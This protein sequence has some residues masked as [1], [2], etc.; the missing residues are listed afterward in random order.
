MIDNKSTFLEL[1]S[2]FNKNQSINFNQEIQNKLDIINDTKLQISYLGDRFYQQ[3]SNNKSTNKA[4]KV[5]VKNLFLRSNK[6]PYRN[7]SRVIFK[8]LVEKTLNNLNSTKESRSKS[9]KK[10]N[11]SNIS[12]K[13]YNKKELSNNSRV[14]ISN[15][16]RNVSINYNENKD[17]KDSNNLKSSF[18]FKNLTNNFKFND[19]NDII[20]TNSNDESSFRNNKL[21]QINNLKKRSSILDQVEIRKKKINKITSNFQSNK[22]LSISN[23][24]DFIIKNNSIIDFD[25]FNFDLELKKHNENE[26]LASNHINSNTNITSNIITNKKKQ[27]LLNKPLY[28]FKILTS[29]YFKDKISVNNVNDNSNNNIT[30][31]K[32]VI[33][34]DQA[35]SSSKNKIDDMLNSIK[36]PKFLKHQ[37]SINSSLKRQKSKDKDTTSPKSIRKDTNQYIEKSN[38]SNHQDKEKEKQ[39]FNKLLEQEFLMNK[40][41][42][43]LSLGKFENKFKKHLKSRTLINSNNFNDKDIYII[44]SNKLQSVIKSC[45]ESILEQSERTKIFNYEINQLS[46]NLSKYKDKYKH[47]IDENKEFENNT[48]EDFKVYKYNEERDFL[49]YNTKKNQLDHDI[50]LKIN[51]DIALKYG[52]R[53]ADVYNFNYNTGE[54]EDFILMDLFDKKKTYDVKSPVLDEFNAKEEKSYNLF[55]NNKDYIN[56]KS[57][58]DKV[59]YIIDYVNLRNNHLEEE[60]ENKLKSI[61]KE[62]KQNNYIMINEEHNEDFFNNNSRIKRDKTD[63]SNKEK[64]IIRNM[65][66]KYKKDKVSKSLNYNSELNQVPG[67]KSN[68]KSIKELKLPNINL[69]KSVSKVNNK[70]SN[71][72]LRD[73]TGS[74]AI[75]NSQPTQSYTILSKVRSLKSKLLESFSMCSSVAPTVMKY[76]F[77]FGFKQIDE[78]NKFINVD[79]FDYVLKSNNSETFLYRLS[80]LEKELFDKIMNKLPGII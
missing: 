75:D 78:I 29:K 22:N 32:I 14:V 20:N 59:S 51:P 53:I 44:N 4:K 34:E 19:I 54:E 65:K 33:S 1:N 36:T 25:T 45:Y 70:S 31:S 16:K 3:L 64:T 42:Y 47:Y 63:D 80:V 23:V 27:S 17:N 46:G 9:K 69:N 77:T 79:L 5:N 30:N 2:S 71:K 67:L 26:S 12:S 8:G 66:V 39:E 37:N 18:N 56:D 41:N 57:G 49:N 40:K 7:K 15:P 76:F 11:K 24:S 21:K 60:L 6:N 52:V 58:K 72:Q 74:D 73:S 55:L 68:N 38:S 35:S 28:Y 13:N 61:K 62:K 43:S 48:Q 10:L 50:V